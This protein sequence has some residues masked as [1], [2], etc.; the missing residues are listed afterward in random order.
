M[1]HALLIA[2]GVSVGKRGEDSISGLLGAADG[3]AALGVNFPAMPS[4][5]L[6]RDQLTVLIDWT[7]CA[8]LSLRAS[9]S[10][11][12]TKL[13]AESPESCHHGWRRHQILD[14]VLEDVAEL[15]RKGGKPLNRSP[16]DGHSPETGLPVPTM[17]SEANE[18]A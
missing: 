6:S 2:S 15:R 13:V 17:P 18:A 11:M 4:Q 5:V 3:E 7:S 8:I 1:L 12:P 16:L 14:P 10:S 9:A